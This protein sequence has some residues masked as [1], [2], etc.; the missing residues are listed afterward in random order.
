MDGLFG[1][2]IEGGFALGV[3]LIRRSLGRTN[4]TSRRLESQ[5]Q[6]S[7]RDLIEKWTVIWRGPSNKFE[8]IEMSIGYWRGLCFQI[9]LQFHSLI[10]FEL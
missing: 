10:K 4:Q 2:Q 8:L 5:F 1:M 6:V 3:L 7:D 9:K